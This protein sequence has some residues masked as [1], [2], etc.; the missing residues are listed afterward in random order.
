MLNSFWK[1]E[2][3]FQFLL[4]RILIFIA[5]IKSTTLT[6]LEIVGKIF[7]LNAHKYRSMYTYVYKYDVN[8]YVCLATYLIIKYDVLYIYK[9][10]AYPMEIEA[11][12]TNIHKYTQTHTN[13]T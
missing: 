2:D 9:S 10:L 13:T 7:S 6:S 4:I 8:I 5:Y 11:K 1:N 12:H 3:F